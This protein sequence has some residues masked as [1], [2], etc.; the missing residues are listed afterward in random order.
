M[1]NANKEQIATMINFL[2]GKANEKLLKSHSCWKKG[3]IGYYLSDLIDKFKEICEKKEGIPDT[4]AELKKWILNG[5]DSWREYSYTDRSLIYDS[6]IAEILCTPSELKRNKHG[7]RKPNRDEE[8]LDVQ[9]RAL[10]EASWYL[11]LFYRSYYAKNLD[12][13]KE[14]T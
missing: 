10:L 1:M 14:E 8:W 5:A 12:K 4:T 3:V 7:E 11:G 9:A 6:D 2:S 13:G